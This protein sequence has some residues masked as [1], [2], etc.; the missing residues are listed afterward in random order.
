VPFNLNDVLL[1]QLV[2]NALTVFAAGY[3]TTSSA[4]TWL[5]YHV[6]AHQE[7]QLKMRREVDQVLQ[8]GPVTQDNLKEVGNCD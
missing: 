8:G 6:T 1:P 7:V 3:D 2:S 5:M 4:L